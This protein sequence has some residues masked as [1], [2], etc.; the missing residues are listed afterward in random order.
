MRAKAHAAQFGKVKLCPLLSEHSPPITDND[1]VSNSI[2]RKIKCFGSRATLHNQLHTGACLD[3][4]H[5]LDW[6]HLIQE[7]SRI[8][9]KCAMVF[10]IRIGNRQVHLGLAVAKFFIEEILKKN[11]IRHPIC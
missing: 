11:N 1:E 9:P 10:N 2:S 8:R 7:Y 6:G 5:G 3:D 4:L